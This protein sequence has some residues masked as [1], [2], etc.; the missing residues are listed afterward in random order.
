MSFYCD[1]LLLSLFNFI[2]QNNIKRKD[3][4]TAVRYVNNLNLLEN[5]KKFFWKMK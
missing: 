1:I 2:K 3:I 4:V 5:K